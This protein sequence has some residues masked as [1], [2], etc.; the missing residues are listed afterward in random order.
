M[1]VKCQD[2]PCL[3]NPQVQS[4]ISHFIVGIKYVNLEMDFE[5]KW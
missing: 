1:A 4:I 5:D 3:P 2:P